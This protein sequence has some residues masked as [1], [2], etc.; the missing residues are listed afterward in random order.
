MPNTIKCILFMVLIG[1]LSGC[2]TSCSDKITARS[3]SEDGK[4]VAI[5]SIRDCGATT[6]YSTQLRL[7]E[8][9]DSRFDPDMP[10]IV[11]FSGDEPIKMMWAG[12]I[13]AVEYSDRKIFSPMNAWKDVKV[14]Y[15]ESQG[16]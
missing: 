14:I 12:K 16:T 5:S 2:D 8:S 4:Y 7:Q 11:V 3:Y 10:P 1:S 13:L 15:R 6:D 9:K